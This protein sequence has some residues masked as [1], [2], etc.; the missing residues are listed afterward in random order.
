MAEAPPILF[1]AV[2]VVLLVAWE[3]VNTIAPP[4]G[5]IFALGAL[6]WHLYWA[7]SAFEISR[8]AIGGQPRLVERALY[9]ISPVAVGLL[10]VIVVQDAI[11]MLRAFS[12][13]LV[14]VGAVTAFA[15]MWI[16]ASA[17]VQAEYGSGSV[18]WYRT[19]GTFLLVFYLVVGVWCLSRRLEQLD[20]N[21]VRASR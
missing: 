1:V 15:A 13:P 5:E 3:V 2:Y 12:V 7:Y 18:P 4:L 8:N 9:V 6:T 20:A 19:V 14:M 10:G 11:P 16:T 21:E 17:I